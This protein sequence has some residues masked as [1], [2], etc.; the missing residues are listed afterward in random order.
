MSD[1]ECCMVKPWNCLVEG[2][3]LY[4]LFY[5]F[6]NWLKRAFYLRAPWVSVNCY[7]AQ[8]VPR[9]REFK[10]RIVPPIWAIELNNKLHYYK[11]HFRLTLP[12]VNSCK[13][14]NWQIFL[15]IRRLSLIKMKCSSLVEGDEGCIGQEVNC[16]VYD[17]PYKNLQHMYSILIW[18]LGQS[19]C[20]SPST[21]EL[22]GQCA[23]CF[24]MCNCIKRAQF[25]CGAMHRRW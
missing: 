19:I 2:D 24:T 3:K 25:I 16:C 21:K 1:N 20:S 10:V 9:A 11:L 18:L 22:H 6:L 13:E 15:Y 8:H 17:K 23:K 14:H 12:R 5:R 7:P 4:L